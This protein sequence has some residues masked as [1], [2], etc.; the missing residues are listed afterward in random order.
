MLT[1]DESFEEFACVPDKITHTG[2]PSHYCYV[3][4]LKEVLGRI[5][6]HPKIP[7]N[8]AMRI[9]LKG[10]NTAVPTVKL[11]GRLGMAHRI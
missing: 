2:N 11:V 1:F 8:F 7:P 6:N 4:T 10:P 3:H 9:K 5:R